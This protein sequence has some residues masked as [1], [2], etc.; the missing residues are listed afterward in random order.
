M[1]FE[2]KRFNNTSSINDYLKTVLDSFSE[3]NIELTDRN[4]MFPEL[5]NLPDG[6][7]TIK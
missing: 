6:A 3:T 5:D 4:F 2:S 7:Y 1:E